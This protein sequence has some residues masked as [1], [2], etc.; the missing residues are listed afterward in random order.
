[1]GRGSEALTARSV[2]DA[3]KG[4]RAPHTQG[5]VP[6]FADW[7]VAAAE[8]TNVRCHRPGTPRDVGDAAHINRPAILFHRTTTHVPQH[9]ARPH[10]ELRPSHV[11]NHDFV[12]PMPVAS[13]LSTPAATRQQ[14]PRPRLLSTGTAAGVAHSSGRRTWPTPRAH[15][16]RVSQHMTNVWALFATRTGCPGTSEGPACRNT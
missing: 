5:W 4:L 16:P 2:R 6:R 7:D 1:M 9:H 13:T 10:S 8:R 11:P 3:W 15:N 14:R 12:A